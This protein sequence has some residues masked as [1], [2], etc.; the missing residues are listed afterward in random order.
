MET[1]TET[2]VNQYLNDCFEKTDNEKD[3]LKFETIWR[4]LCSN[5]EYF[6]KLIKRRNIITHLNT[7]PGIT[8]SAQLHSNYLRG[9]RPKLAQNNSNVGIF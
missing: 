4:C 8:Y 3:I 1:D 9:W 6:N 2:L 7:L 5:P